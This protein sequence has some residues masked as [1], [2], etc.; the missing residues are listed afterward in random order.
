ML[1]ESLREQYSFKDSIK[2]YKGYKVK[3]PEYTISTIESAF[4]TIGLKISYFP[5]SKRSLKKYYPFQA[6]MAILS[7]E[8]KNEDIALITSGKG[9]S[10]KLARAS[11]TAE[12]IERFTGYGLAKGNIDHYLSKIKLEE[13]WKRRSRYNKLIENSFPFHSMGILDLIPKKYQS[14][15]HDMAKSVC[16]SLTKKKMYGFPEIFILKHGD[17][18]GLASGNTLEEATLHAIFEVIERLVGFYV[19]D[20]LPSCKKISKE[21][22]TPVS[23]THL[24]AHET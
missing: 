4:D 18:T 16:Y 24:R 22:I 15:Y 10:S 1:K 7:P 19:L 2:E 14:Q 3:S 21:S 9:V 6:G 23:Y 8:Q 20:T 13:I 11:A 5:K 17:S 12:L